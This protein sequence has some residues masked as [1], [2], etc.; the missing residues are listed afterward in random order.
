MS[1][2][3]EA[4]ETYI[5][6]KKSNKHELQKTRV[7]RG[8][9]GKIAVLEMKQRDGFVRAR[10]LK[11]TTAL[12]IQHELN[13]AISEIST[14]ITD[15]HGSYQGAKYNHKTVNHNAKQFVDGMAHTNAIESVWTVL[16]RGFYGAYHSFSEK[17]L[18]RYVDEFM[19]RLN[20]GNVKVHTMDRIDAML[21]MAMNNKRLSYADLVG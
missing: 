13:L 6:G 8:V 4:D 14:L 17:H 11:D 18:Q 16:K 3:I 20:D 7:G 21:N 19:V 15:E 1:G 12:T 9:V 10:V 5:G 2:I